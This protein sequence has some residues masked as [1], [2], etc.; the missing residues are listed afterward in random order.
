VFSH[1]TVRP[2]NIVVDAVSLSL[3]KGSLIDFATE[4]I[5]SNFRVAENPQVRVYSCCLPYDM[6]SHYMDLIGERKRMWLWS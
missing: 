2:S 6:Y 4:L 1:P 5:G 3:L